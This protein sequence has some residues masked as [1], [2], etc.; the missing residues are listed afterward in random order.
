MIVK[1]MPKDYQLNLFKQL[2]NLIEKAMTVNVYT[3]FVYR[4]KI[5]VGHIEK[6]VEKV[7]MY[8]NG[9]RYDIQDEIRI[10]FLKTVEDAY[11]AALKVE[12]KLAKK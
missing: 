7:A 10:L 1:F 5:R 9:L 2:Q 3:K 8:I 6:D 4:L 11:Q 12:D